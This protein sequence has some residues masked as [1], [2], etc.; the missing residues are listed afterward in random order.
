[1]KLKII[2]FGWNTFSSDK[3]ESFTV[4]TKSWEIT[5]LDKHE[6]L[7]TVLVPST[8][9]VVYKD[10]A[11]KDV[12]K[13]FAVWKWII[14]IDNSNVKIL[15]DMLV[16]PEDIKQWEL[17]NAIQQAHE[18]KEKYKNASTKEDMEKFLQASEQLSKVQAKVKLV[19]LSK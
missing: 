2:S 6:S 9:K 14:E 19:E 11:W 15:T 1:M 4:N 13:N 12:F 10:D 8:I 17:E 16:K 3:V 5:V 7:I 18:L